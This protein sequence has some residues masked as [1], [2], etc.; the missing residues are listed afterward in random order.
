MSALVRPERPGMN[1]DIP[2]SSVDALTA[3]REAFAAGQYA[4]A[5]HHF[6]QVLEMDPSHPWGWHGRGDA[7]QLMGQHADAKDAYLRAAALQPDEP[8]HV[9]GAERA[10]TALMEKGVEGKR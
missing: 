2:Q 6:G 10:M 4:E 9:A 7:L 3:G 5:L 1:I 8:L